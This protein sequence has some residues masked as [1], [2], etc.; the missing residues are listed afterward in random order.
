MGDDTEDEQQ[1]GKGKSDA[2]P[3]APLPCQ[4]TEQCGKHEAEADCRKEEIAVRHHGA[5]GKEV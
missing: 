2:A 3:H 4:A 1:Q 5:G